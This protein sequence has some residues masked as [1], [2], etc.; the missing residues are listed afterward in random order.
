MLPALGSG[1]FSDF[2][3]YLERLIMPAVSLS[4]FWWAYLARLVRSSMLEAL[5]QPFVRTSRAYGLQNGP[6]DTGSC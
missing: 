4:A 6:S 1:S 2:G 3:G 5:G